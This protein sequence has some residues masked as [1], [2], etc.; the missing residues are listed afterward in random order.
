MMVRVCEMTFLLASS[1]AVLPAFAGPAL[2]VLVESYP[3]HLV[4][5]D[6]N[7]ITWRDGTVMPV[8]DEAKGLNF[9]E[10]LK[11]PSILSQFAIPYPL[12]SGLKVP[13]L[14]EDPGRIR[15]EPF[16]TKMYGDCRKGDVEKRLKPVAWLPRYGGGT[17][18]ATSVN[19]VADRLSEVSRELEMLPKAMMKYLIPSAG[20]YNCRA[21]TE[22]DRTSVHSYGAAI[23][24]N[25]RYSDYW[26][27]TKKKKGQFTWV[28]RIPLEIV[29]I[30]EQ[31]GFIWGG[32]WYHFDTMHF[33]Y[34][35]EMTR[36]AER[37]WPRD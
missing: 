14:N 11:G 3:D 25:D 19:S 29:H 17:L 15:Y 1:L 24:I 16:F 32:K 18:M 2:D 5:H 28:N 21:I 9:E 33:E 27:W 22:T 34:R 13:Q 12:G 31:H 20:I 8:G 30:F 36:L 26:V 4:S 23:D 35:P 6:D 7:S 37:G 10:L